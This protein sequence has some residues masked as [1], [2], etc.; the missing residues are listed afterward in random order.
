[1]ISV[2][3]VGSVSAAAAVPE[4]DTVG[5]GKLTLGATVE[6][7]NEN[8]N[9]TGHTRTTEIGYKDV[10]LTLDKKGV[11]KVTTQ[12]DAPTIMLKDTDKLGNWAVRYS[13][14][15]EDQGEIKTGNNT[16]KSSTI[17]ITGMSPNPQLPTEVTEEEAKAAIANGSGYITKMYTVEYSIYNKDDTTTGT[18]N[19]AKGKNTTSPIATVTEVITVKIN[20]N[21]LTLTASN[22]KDIVWNAE[23]AKEYAAQLAAEKEVQGTVDQKEQLQ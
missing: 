4:V 12:V 11:G 19:S 23:K 6:S 9:K 3:F 8:E 13:I 2:L 14:N 21:N 1:M 10:N 22:K 17:S 7:Q 16:K 5:F 18:Y 20:V 15:G